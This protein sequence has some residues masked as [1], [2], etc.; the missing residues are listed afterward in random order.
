MRRTL[1]FYR[2]I[3]ILFAVVLNLRELLGREAKH[4]PIATNRSILFYHNPKLFCTM[5]HTI[6][7][8]TSQVV[9][10]SGLLLY[11]H[12]QTRARYGELHHDQERALLIDG[13]RSWFIGHE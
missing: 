8:A 3:K 9:R 5:L 12:A 11:H 13:W 1:V 4:W 2:W 7:S 10:L 6:H